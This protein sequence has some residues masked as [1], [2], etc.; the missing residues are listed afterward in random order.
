[1][2]VIREIKK[3]PLSIMVVDDG[4]MDD[5]YS[6]VS[7]EKVEV[8][9]K[10]EKNLGKGNALRKAFNYIIDR[11]L[12]CDA[13]IIMDADAQHLPEELDSFMDKLKQGSFFV[14]GNRLVNPRNMPILRIITN[15][16]MSFIVSKISGQK[17]PDTQCGFKAIR[18]EV[19]EKT[20]LRTSKY[21]IDSELIIQASSLGYRIESIPVKSVYRKENS[22]INPVFDTVR[23]ITYIL[24]IR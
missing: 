7:E 19:L 3:R 18:R 12:D 13:V 22:Y 5:T 23:F 24:S 10:N 15:K 9:I 6:R 4:S 20:V 11:N 1:V 17:I 8:L 16:I 2:K 14:M 21:E